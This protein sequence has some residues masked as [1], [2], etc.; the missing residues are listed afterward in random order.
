[1]LADHKKLRRVPELLMSQRMQQLYPKLACDVV[2]RMFTVDNPTPKP[3][4]VRVA[5]ENIKRSGLRMRDL[6]HDAYVT[7]RSFG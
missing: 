7:L 2:E 1:V 3:G 4:A 6:A 5:R